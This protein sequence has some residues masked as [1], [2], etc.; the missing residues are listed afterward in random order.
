[1]EITFSLEEIDDAANQ[2]LANGLKKIVVFH[3]PMGAGKTTL[4]KAIARQMGVTGITSSPTFSLVNEYETAEGNPLYH[5]D[6]YRLNSEE[7]A[8]DMGIDEYFYSGNMCLIEWPEKTP[9]LIPLDHSSITI[10]QLAD[11]RRHVVLK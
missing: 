9:N 3:A 6:L 2:M 4:I 7:E 8:Y 5:F 11:G 1:M 10:K